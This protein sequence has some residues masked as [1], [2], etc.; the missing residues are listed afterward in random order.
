MIPTALMVHLLETDPALAFAFAGACLLVGLSGP[1][2]VWAYEKRSEARARRVKEAA[3]RP[4]VKRG[5][6]PAG[7]LTLS[8][9]AS[10][11]GGISLIKEN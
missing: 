4:A 10:R 1:L 9:G 7:S 2:A 8:E 11:E 3:R 6:A 5:S